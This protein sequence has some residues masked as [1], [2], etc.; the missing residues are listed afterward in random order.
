MTEELTTLE[1]A[2][3]LSGE[4]VWETRAVPRHGIR[5][6]WLSDGPH[7]IRKQTGSA[8]HLGLGASQPATCFPTAA[9]VANSWDPE[10]ALSVGEA[11]G[12]EAADQ[13]VDVLLG[14]GLNVKRSPLCRRNFSTSP[15]TPCSPGASPP[16]TCGGSSRAASRR[17]RS[18]SR[19]TAKSCGA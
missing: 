7:G 15:R 8:D 2:A 5:T 4:S 1:K 14:P 16:D 11:L 9:T 10:L 19:P 18:T 12:A 3:L 17:A 13:G 6:L